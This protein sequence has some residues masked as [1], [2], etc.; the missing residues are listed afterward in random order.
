MTPQERAAAST[1]AATRNV[2][3]VKR[4]AGYAHQSGA[5]NALAR[6][7]VQAE[8]AR[9][10]GERL[11]KEGLELAV[12]VHLEL[13]TSK[14]VSASVRLGAVKLMYDRTLGGEG[15]T[16]GKDPD[17]MTAAELGRERMRLE[18]II[19]E[20]LQEAAT[21]EGQAVEVSSDPSP[22]VFD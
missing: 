13:L 12:D 22:G 2:S 18:R 4:V 3:E 21:I 16:E 11:F 9:I 14:A 7:A 5:H 17:Q 19:A 6:P 1:Y 8:I 10:Q 15:A 20:K